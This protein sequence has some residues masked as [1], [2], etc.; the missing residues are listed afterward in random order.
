MTSPLVALI[1]DPD[2]DPG[3]LGQAAK[4][5]ADEAG[6][7]VNTFVRPCE[8]ILGPLGE[9][10]RTASLKVLSSLLS[11][12]VR[13]EVAMVNDVIDRLIELR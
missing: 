10:C 12:S 6:K 2:S 9:S 11:D 5:T 13:R 7:L 1:T 4:L 3:L 8:R